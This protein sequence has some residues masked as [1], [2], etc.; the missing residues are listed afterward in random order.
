[1]RSRMQIVVLTV[2]VLATVAAL[3]APVQPPYPY[4]VIQSSCAP[5]DGPAVVVTLTREPAQCGRTD[6]GPYLAIGVWRGL[7]IHE[8]QTVTFGAGSDAGF[9]SRCAKEGDCERAE[10]GTVVFE[11]YQQGSSAAGRY[12][13]QFKGGEIVKGTFDVKWCEMRVRC[14]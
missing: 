1:M 2:L 13:L 4:G 6:A 3:S 12:E 5:W 11:R 14:G 10:S 7:P 9:A 8:G